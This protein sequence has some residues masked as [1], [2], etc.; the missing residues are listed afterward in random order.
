MKPF[1]TTP[2]TAILAGL[3]FLATM[4]NASAD[5]DFR[6]AEYCTILLAPKLQEKLQ[7]TIVQRVGAALLAEQLMPRVKSLLS[8]S[9]S[10]QTDRYL[11]RDNP[12]SGVRSMMNSLDHSGERM[13]DLITPEQQALFAKIFKAG[14]IA[15]IKAHFIGEIPAAGPV[16]FEI[17]YTKYGET[18]PDK[19]PARESVS[20]KD[21]KTITHTEINIE[22][23]HGTAKILAQIKSMPDALEVLSAKDSQVSCFGALWLLKNAMIE[24]ASR[25]RVCEALIP[26]INEGSDARLTR[27]QL[28][29]KVYVE[30]FCRWADRGQSA[31]LQELAQLPKEQRDTV[32]AALKT[33]L[34]VDPAGAESVVRARMDDFFFRT[35]TTRLLEGLKEEEKGSPEKVAALLELLRSHQHAAPTRDATAPTRKPAAPNNRDMPGQQAC[36]AAALLADL[37]SGDS[38]RTAKALMQLIRTVPE[39]PNPSVAEALA[40]ILLEHKSMPL[41]INAAWALENWGSEKSLPALN[42]ASADPNTMLQKRAKKTL[43]KLA[44]KTS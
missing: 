3:V 35:D 9:L 5:D 40:K 28:A 25:A 10:R 37:Q 4:I 29:S 33:L 12:E 20:H 16:P 31:K 36:D 22:E 11:L 34:R 39:K 32:A 19:S 8:M 26:H 43:A 44:D 23:H 6:P 7:L 2:R 18:R 1:K 42:K 41:R 27:Q 21:G 17:R 38:A 15:P 13:R 14:E 30:A 24:E